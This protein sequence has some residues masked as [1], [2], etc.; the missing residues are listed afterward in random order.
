M[1]AVIDHDVVEA[2]E[3]GAQ[4]KKFRVR[5]IHAVPVR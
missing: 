1:L 2:L 4:R 3:L 5:R